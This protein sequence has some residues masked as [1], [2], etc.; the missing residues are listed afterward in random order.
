MRWNVNILIY[1]LINNT[2][3]K[4][5]LISIFF[6]RHLH[7]TG[8]IRNFIIVSEEAI[9]KGIRRIVALTGL[10]AMKAQKKTSIL[11][12][13]LD[14]LQI[15]IEADKNGINTKEH[16]KKIVELTD[17]VSHAIISSWKKVYFIYVCIFDICI[18]NIYIYC[19]KN[20][21]HSNIG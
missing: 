7:Y 17:D 5:F 16:I 9:A 12:N 6:Y 3:Y 1:L 19:I 18:F 15:S 14:E 13:Y 8:H 11:Q 4:H 20:I 21:I 10:E 2:I